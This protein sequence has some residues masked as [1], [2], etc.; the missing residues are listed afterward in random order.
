MSGEAG[1]PLAFRVLN[2]VAIINQLASRAFENALPAGLS[3]AQFS[4]LNHLVRLGDDRTPARIAAAFQ[5]P[6]PTMT[7]TLG[8]LA[9]AGLVRL[10][11]DPDDGR[12]KRVRLTPEGTAMRARAVAATAPLLAGLGEAVP[13]PLLASLL[14]LLADL[15]AR[16]D[17]AREVAPE[18]EPG[19]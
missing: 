3:L 10:V 7:H 16:L 13:E 18:G 2:E 15:R 1:D 5:V 9:A 14:P 19:D 8:R 4:V 11:P 6:R 12:G 17:A